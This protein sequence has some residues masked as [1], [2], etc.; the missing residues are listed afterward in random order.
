M[1]LA[2]FTLVRNEQF[3]LPIWLQHYLQFV[4]AEDVYVLD[5]ESRGDAADVLHNLHRQYRFHL[6]P[7]QHDL[8]YSSAWLSRIT[9]YFQ[10]YL[11]QTYPA[12]LFSAADE[13]VLPTPESELTLQALAQRLSDANPYVRCNAFE[14]VH[15]HPDEPNLEPQ[16]PILE[17][18]KWWYHTEHY[19][20]PLLARIPLLWKPGWFGAYNVP[21]SQPITKEL[22]LVHLHK[23]DYR[24]LVER[25]QQLGTQRWDPEERLRGSLRHNLLEEPEQ[26]ARWL[27]ANAD[28]TTQFAKLYPIP[29]SVKANLQLCSP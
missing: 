24:M 9:R 6:L 17:S 27:A 29:A 22:L 25:H 8:C 20:K 7:V 13:L 5:H 3:F 21:T 26:L 2:I 19:S 23:L 28:D 15:K 11:L 10:Q 14:V 4:P 16:R 12:V 18:R 1:R